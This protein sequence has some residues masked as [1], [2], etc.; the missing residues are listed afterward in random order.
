MQCADGHRHWG[1]HGAA[2]L[3]LSGGD[4]VVLQHRSLH[5]HEGGT[6]GLPGGARDSHEDVVQTALREA[7][8]EAAIGAA[9]VR[10]IA[11]SVADHGGWSYA[12]VLAEAIAEVHPHAANWES[13]E[14]RWWAR[15]EVAQLPLHPGLA[16]TW[17]ALQA[18]TSALTV[19]VDGANVVGARADGWWRD[20][21]AAAGRLFESLLELA[22]RGLACDTGARLPRI[23][24]TVEGEVARNPPRARAQQW[25]ERAVSVRATTGSGDDAVIAE[26][27]GHG[28]DVLVVTAD[29]GLRERLP[30]HVGRRGPS[31][32]LDRLT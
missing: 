29:R 27:A 8:E 6:W 21:P 19:V 24:L 18:P 15:Q 13:D 30:D 16:A 12:T 22:R 7:E 31:W 3:L 28:G 14:V 1:R 11:V 5:T 2:G 25:W 4:R 32:L 9:S 23:V 20:R 10:P 17:T 26:A